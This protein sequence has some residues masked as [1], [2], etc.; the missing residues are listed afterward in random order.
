M[1]PAK[2]KTA[3]ETEQ[4]SI[5]STLVTAFSSDPAARWV[6]RDPHQYLAHFPIFIRAF[7]GKAFEHGTAYVADDCA[8][9]ALWLPPNV[10]PDEAELKEFLERTVPYDLQ[11]EV[12]CL[13]EQ[14]GQCHPKD[15]HWYLPLIGVDAHLQGRGYGS[16]LLRHTLTICDRDQA[17]AYLESSNPKNIA[18]YQRHGF[19]LLGTIQAGASPQVFPMARKPQPGDA[20]HS[21]GY[22]GV[23]HESP[24]LRVT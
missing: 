15:P 3:D 14:M 19:E 24:R 23:F 7:G 16:A 22:N 17:P 1:R 2:I 12:F 11:E 8:A 5:V 4:Y 20:G 21:T 6:Y 18:L 13:F 10:H 9:A